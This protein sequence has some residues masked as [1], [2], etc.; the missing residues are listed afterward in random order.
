MRV[1]YRGDH[2]H[3]VSKTPN[4]NLVAEMAWLQSTYTR[5]GRPKNDPG[6]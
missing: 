3:W 4:A 5:V 6:P 2:Y 1:Q